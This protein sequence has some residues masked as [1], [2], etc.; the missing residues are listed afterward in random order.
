[1]QSIDY[2]PCG[3]GLETDHVRPLHPV[4]SARAHVCCDELAGGVE[5]EAVSALV[6]PGCDSLYVI[7]NI[8]EGKAL[9]YSY[10]LIPMRLQGAL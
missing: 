5:E 8:R 4:Q 3:T 1:M 10:F 6:T 7:L 2:K 9:V